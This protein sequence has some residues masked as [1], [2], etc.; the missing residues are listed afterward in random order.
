[1]CVLSA[2]EYRHVLDLS[3]HAWVCACVC[4]CAAA[5]LTVPI[6]ISIKAELSRRVEHLPSTALTPSSSLCLYCFPFACSFTL[7]Q[8]FSSFF[9]F[10]PSSS[11]PLPLMSRRYINVFSS[12]HSRVVLTAVLSVVE[13]AFVS[14]E[15]TDRVT[16]CSGWYA[17]SFLSSPG[18]ALL[19]YMM[20]LPK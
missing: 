17:Y 8:F 16:A 5:G 13:E 1:M 4:H 7:L 14:A 19:P 6:N 9:F 11:L 2:K 15:V 12:I 3:M 10:P 18:S 20:L